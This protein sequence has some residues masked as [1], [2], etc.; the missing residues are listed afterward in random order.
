[1]AFHFDAQIP[2]LSR[3]GKKQLFFL[4]K[5]LGGGSISPYIPLFF[6]GE[7]LG[8]NTVNLIIPILSLLQKKIPA[9]GGLRFG[10]RIFT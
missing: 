4:H 7:T 10:C 3:G 2:L 5:I 1:M 9:F 6:F 8:V